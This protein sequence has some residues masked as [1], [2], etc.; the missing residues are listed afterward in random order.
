MAECYFTASLTDLLIE[1]HCEQKSTVRAKDHA[2]RMAGETGREL[3]PD[4]RRLGRQALVGDLLRHLTSL[5]RI[6]AVAEPI[7]NVGQRWR[8][9]HLSQRCLRRAPHPASPAAAR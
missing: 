5:P 3:R 4:G 2:G 6:A 7:A 1:L 8:S 9:T